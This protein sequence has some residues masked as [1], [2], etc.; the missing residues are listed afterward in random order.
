MNCFLG[1]DTSN[2]T[3]SC[4]LC[5]ESGEIVAQKKQL[6]P[7]KPG[8]KGL[9]QADALFHH[10]V[11]LPSLLDALLCEAE[12]PT[13]LGIGVS[14][15]PRPVKGSYMPCFLAGVTAAC[16]IASALKLSPVCLSH[17][18][19]HIA[20]AA[21]SAGL[22]CEKTKSFYA[23]HLSGGTT[24]LVQADVQPDGSFALTLLGGT[25][26]LSA[27][28][29]IDR[30]ALMLGL[31]FPGG[32]ALEALALSAGKPISSVRGLKVSVN[33]V[34]CHL[35]GLENMAQKQYAD[36]IAPQE[37]AL[38]TFAFL[39]KTLLRLIANAC[40]L[41]GEKPVLFAGGVMSSVI[42]RPA[43]GAAFSAYFSDGAYAADN[44]AGIALLTKRHCDFSAKKEPS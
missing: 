11:A 3:T 34:K 43:L 13:L 1:I 6:L 19:G 31:P 42:M 28:Q 25:E 29:A 9:R 18:E 37:I 16:A 22:D 39:Q 7:V 10:T 41:H 35:S 30:I 20:A 24:E 38:F 36:G 4:A 2:Y 12:H 14:D 8:E 40:T 5:R 17:Q 27:G 44:A 23:L 26:D 32:A 21:Y 33:G 15:K